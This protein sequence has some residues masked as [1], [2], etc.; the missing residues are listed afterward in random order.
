MRPPTRRFSARA[1]PPT[2]SVVRGSG[3]SNPSRYPST[4]ARARSIAGDAR[5]ILREEPARQPLRAEVDRAR[6]ERPRLARADDHLRRAAADVDDRDRPPARDARARQRADE[7]ELA[8]LDRAENP[9][10]AAG[11]ALEPVRELGAVRRLP[12]RARDQD[13][14]RADA[15]TRVP[16]RRARRRPRRSARASPRESRRALRCPR[17]GGAS[18]APRA[19][20]GRS[21]TRAG[22][23]CSN[24]RRRPRRARRHGD[25]PTRRQ[26]NAPWRAAAPARAGA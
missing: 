23:R 26:P 16:S 20:C 9:C 8:L 15:G 11:R 13:L 4:S 18:R 7:R 10:A 5:R 17:R 2:A 22:G 21:P 12:P 14:D 24:R 25:D 3:G 19:R 1:L 6:P